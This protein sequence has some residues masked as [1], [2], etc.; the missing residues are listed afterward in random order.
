MDIYF[1]QEDLLVYAFV[2]TTSFLSSAILILIIYTT[3]CDTFTHSDISI[4]G[5]SLFSI[6]FLGKSIC[7]YFLKY[8]WV[9]LTYDSNYFKS[10]LL[11]SNL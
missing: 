8:H 5:P 6:V 1:E 10:L 7:F 11:R 2:Y 4:D 3:F 9:F